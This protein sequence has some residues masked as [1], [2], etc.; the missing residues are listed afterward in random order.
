MQSL[1]TLNSSPYK[2]SPATPRLSR[3]VVSKPAK[4]RKAGELET[5][6]SRIPCPR[7]VVIGPSS[8]LPGAL[9]HVP[10]IAGLD[11]LMV[12][13]WLEGEGFDEF[14]RHLQEFKEE[15]H[16]EKL[17][18][19]EVSERAF[20]FGW[21]GVSFNMSRTGA[22]TYP[23][24]LESGDIILLF[25]NHRATASHPNCRIEIHSMSCWNPSWKV[26]LDRF[27]EL[28]DQPWLHYPQTDRHRA[29]Y[30]R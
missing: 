22:A 8:P 14:R 7:Q 1:N 20:D 6:A 17:C 4:S 25:S 15:F 19:P 30:H 27:L 18:G 28:L 11:K 2:R 23:Y 5:G 10:Y 29:S 21:E 9:P 16:D 3:P 26:V 24:K 12:S 13:F